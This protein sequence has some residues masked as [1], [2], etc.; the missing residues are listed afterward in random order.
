M[1]SHVACVKNQA[2]SLLQYTVAQRST[3]AY[4]YI[5]NL[6][7]FCSPSTSDMY[8]RQG[9]GSSQSTCGRQNQDRA[10]A[11]PERNSFWAWKW[12]SQGCKYK[13]KKQVPDPFQ[14]HFPFSPLYG[15]SLG[16]VCVTVN[17]DETRSPRTS[18]TVTKSPALAAVY[19][20]LYPRQQATM[21]GWNYS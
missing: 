20:W 14:F 15:N 1:T 18:I 17:R 5:P 11:A 7:L 19:K 16:V 9:S 12:G 2:W 4:S 6:W 10:A 13:G 8:L 21:L 3:E